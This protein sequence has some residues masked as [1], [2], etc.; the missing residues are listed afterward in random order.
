M[1][2]GGIRKPAKNHVYLFSGILKLTE[3]FCMLVIL[4]H[5]NS[6][7]LIQKHKQHLLI[8]AAPTCD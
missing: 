7:D 4:G 8:S 5:K 1:G 6:S 3:E 2:K